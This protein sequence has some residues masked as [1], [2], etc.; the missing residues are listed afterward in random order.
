MALMKCEECGEKVSDKAES[1]PNCGAIISLAAKAQ[2]APK[3]KTDEQ[4]TKKIKLLSRISNWI[5]VIGFFVMFNGNEYV[6]LLLIAITV[7]WWNILWW[8]Y[9][10]RPFT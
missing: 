1:S 2:G 10:K 7:I 9:G 4:I 3:L 6:G 5:G 8:K